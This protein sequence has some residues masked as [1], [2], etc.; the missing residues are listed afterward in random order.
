MLTFDLNQTPPT[1]EE[2]AKARKRRA[3]AVLFALGIC[4]LA[5]IS[6]HLLSHSTPALKYPSFLE[7]LMKGGFGL[8]ATAGFFLLILLS[9]ASRWPLPVIWFITVW[10]FLCWLDFAF[11]AAQ[12]V[13]HFGDS[14]NVLGL[15]LSFV[16]G[17]VV[18]ASVLMAGGP[19]GKTRGLAD[20]NPSACVQFLENCLAD[21]L[22][23][24]YRQKVAG[25]G[26]KPVVAEAEMIRRRVALDWALAAGREKEHLAAEKERREGIACALV[27]S[28]EPLPSDADAVLKGEE[29]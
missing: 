23:E 21:P 17:I 11:L 19:F 4:V 29:Q 18:I 20:I 13:V 9:G 27:A 6:L 12:L 5:G 2:I 26:R 22:C 28:K 10:F 14:G 16:L 3:R 8:A 15:C 1:V 7:F 24:A 25:L